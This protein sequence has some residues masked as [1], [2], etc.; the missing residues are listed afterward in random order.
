MSAEAERWA[1]VAQS[2]AE[3]LNL[4]EVCRDPLA[5][6]DAARARVGVLNRAGDVAER[7]RMGEIAI[8]TGLRAGQPMAAVIG[9]TWRIGA[10]YQR[11]DMASVD[12]EI[13][14]LAELAA[15][16]R[17]PLARW[18]ELRASASQAAVTGR[19]DQA[20]SLSDDAREI[21]PRMLGDP[22]LTGLSYAF[23]IHLALMRGDRRELLPGTAEEL[24]YAPKLPIV[25]A[26]R[27][28]FMLFDGAREHALAVY[29]HLRPSLRE[30]MAGPRGT[31]V[32]ENA[33]E[34]IEA[35]DDREAAE[36]AHAQWLPWAATAGG[37]VSAGMFCH[38]AA[39]R[40]IGRMAAVIGDLEGAADALRTAVEVNLRLD[41]RPWLAHTWLDLADVLRRRGD[42]GDHAEAATL[43]SRATAEARRL[44]LP[45]PLARADR[46][47]D[48]LAVLR[49][50]DDPLSAREREVAG[51]VA[52]ALSNRQIADR[53]VLSERTVESHVRN[54]L[55]KYGLTNRTELAAHLL[56][57]LS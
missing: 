35:F 53:L 43:T 37:A 47:L 8:R 34:L 31:G 24:A 22:A 21:G 17:L 16:S 30:A 15:T 20:R 54:I 18:H 26:K 38:G 57:G 3:A 13:A 48:R 19:F 50:S 56:G 29:E 11:V 55:T 28:Q 49:R 2:S 41:A 23:G 44:D 9:H 45:G 36:W 14:G 51:L 27:A 46:L 5:L 42:A 6:L 10:A 25:E 33:T 4:A 40:S 12:D 1:D 32:L 52:L 39:A 7:L